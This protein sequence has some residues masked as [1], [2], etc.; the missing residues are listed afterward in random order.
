ML[1]YNP[2]PEKKRCARTATRSRA[3]ARQTHATLPTVPRYTSSTNFSVPRGA[4]S[5][6]RSQALLGPGRP[7]LG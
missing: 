1:A 6:P 5:R 2:C 7:R 3:H 4:S